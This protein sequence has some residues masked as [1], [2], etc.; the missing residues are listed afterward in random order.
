MLILEFKLNKEQMFGYNNTIIKKGGIHM[1]GTF[2]PFN[3]RKFSIGDDLS[4]RKSRDFTTKI[5]C[6]RGQ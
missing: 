3:R 2:H 1:D 5:A 4:G 6:E